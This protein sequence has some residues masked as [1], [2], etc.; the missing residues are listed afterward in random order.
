MVH[1]VESPTPAIDPAHAARRKRVILLCCEDLRPVACSLEDA[2]TSRGW[3]VA[4]EFGSD[5]RPWVQKAPLGTPSLRVLCVPGTVDPSL[6]QTL[7]QAFDPD[8]DADLHILG[9]DDSPGLVH[10]I[11]RLAGIK[12]KPRRS[13]YARSPLS[14][15]TLVENAVRHERGWLV[16]TTAALGACAAVLSVIAVGQVS[17]RASADLVLP[18]ASITAPVT[19]PAEAEPAPR[20]EEPV[21]SAVAAPSFDDWEYDDAPPEEED[22]G[23]LIIFDDEPAATPRTIEVFAPPLAEPRVMPSIPALTAPELDDGLPLSAAIELP[24]VPEVD[25]PELPVGFLPVAGLAVAEPEP[26]TMHDP[27]AAIAQDVTISTPIS[28]IDPF[29][30]Q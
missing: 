9:V 13:L 12:H 23:D 19:T 3:D 26:V 24:A 30:A 11:E 18:A 15:P 20:F 6:S 21:L 25:K 1:Q 8:P 28:T 17:H 10:E 14:Q 2:L 7:R 29:T 22:E 4:V 27:F 5:A 16:G